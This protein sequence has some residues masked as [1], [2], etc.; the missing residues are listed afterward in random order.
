[1]T[2]LLIALRP[3]WLGFRRSFL[4]GTAYK[5]GGAVVQLAA[6]GVIAYLI[7][8]GTASLTGF[9]YE[10]FGAYPDLLSS[11]EMSMLSAVSLGAFMLLLTTGIRGIYSGFYESGDLAYLLSMPL[12]V[13]AV[14]GAK[15]LQNV[16]TNFIMLI[17]FSGAVWLGFGAWHRSG[18]LFY[19]GTAV[20]LLLASTMFTALSSVLV[21]VVMRFVPGPKLKQIILVASLIISVAFFFGIQY[22]S[23]T[24]STSRNTTQTREFLES[25]GSWEFARIGYLPHVWMTKALLSL[26]G[27]HRFSVLE[28]I[29]PLAVVGLG[30]LVLAGLFARFTFLTGWSSS[31]ESGGGGRPGRAGVGAGRPGRAAGGAA[32]RGGSAVADGMATAG[33]AGAD[34]AAVG[35]SV[36]ADGWTT[37][38]GPTVLGGSTIAGTSEVAS[39]Q[40][41]FS[42]RHGATL[43]VLRKDLKWLLRT[44]TMWYSVAVIIIAMGFMTY[45][46]MQGNA[47]EQSLPEQVIV[48][49]ILLLSMTLVMTAS[50]NARSGAVSVSLE[51]K[52]WELIKG[53][54]IEPGAFYLAKLVYGFLSGPVVGVLIV[55]AMSLVPS[56]PTYPIYVSVPTVIAV[57]SVL[58][59][60]SLVLDIMHPDFRLASLTEW[61]AGKQRGI[62]MGK[63]MAVLLMAIPAVGLFGAVFAFPIYYSAVGIFAWMSQAVAE[64]VATAVFA[65]LTVAINW[66][67]YSI[68]CKRL[69]RLFVGAL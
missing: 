38:A 3:S 63:Q 13:E 26:T 67:C 21:M 1:M 10:S 62:A 44:P 39:R 41:S 2:D 46:I 12:R 33:V 19:I 36:R 52:S 59:A 69:G 58:S 29:V 61:S 16:G 20:A 28:G 7:A 45:N 47:A 17:P 22:L 32:G 8:R 60:L 37:V 30:S 48:N 51:G 65:A 68:G 56:V 49:R 24:M 11:I 54:P 6:F 35:G 31:Q 40:S 53:M 25:T 18:P 9:A 27:R 64:A 55:L 66:V 43:G 57:G 50:V 5:R 15:L 34:R 14:F 42:G 4:I 23:S